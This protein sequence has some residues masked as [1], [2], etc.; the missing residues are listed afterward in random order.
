MFAALFRR[1]A[2]RTHLSRKDFT[3]KAISKTGQKQDAWLC[4]FVKLKYVQFHLEVL[5]S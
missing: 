4:V 1:I 3:V 2:L 5:N